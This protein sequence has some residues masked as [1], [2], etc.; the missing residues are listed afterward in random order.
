MNHNKNVLIPT[1]IKELNDEKIKRIF[2]GGNH[3]FCL[4]GNFIY[5]NILQLN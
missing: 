3:N 1:S 5:W 2:I 4:N